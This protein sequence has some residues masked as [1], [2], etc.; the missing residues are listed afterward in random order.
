MTEMFLVLLWNIV[1]EETILK[2]KDSKAKKRRK[3][4]HKCQILFLFFH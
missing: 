3:M 1:E 4:N 2:L